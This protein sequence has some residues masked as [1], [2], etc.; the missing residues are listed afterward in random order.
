MGC[1]TRAG[2]RR[3]ALTLLD[4][5]ADAF[6]AVARLL[7]AIWLLRL[8]ETCKTLHEI[9]TQRV[10]RALVIASKPWLAHDTAGTCD[11]KQRYAIL[12]RAG[13]PVDP[14]DEPKLELSLE[15]L[16]HEFS[17]YFDRHPRFEGDSVV[18]MAGKIRTGMSDAEGY[19]G[20][21]QNVPDA[22]FL[23][24]PGNEF[25]GNVHLDR[26]LFFSVHVRRASDG[27]VAH[28]ASFDLESN[29]EGYIPN[30]LGQ[31]DPGERY[32]TVYRSGKAGCGSTLPALSRREPRKAPKWLGLVTAAGELVDA[33][34]SYP[35][36]NVTAWPMLVEDATAE[37]DEPG[38][39]D[40]AR[41]VSIELRK[42]TSN[43]PNFDHTWFMGAAS[44]TFPI[45]LTEVA[46]VL[47][48]LEWA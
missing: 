39:W 43:V 7:P 33:C 31:D 23:D 13:R 46:A 35:L 37:E 6:E 19:E 17:F 4:L 38:G 36:L 40:E 15:A 30:E 32:V 34:E 12:A 8:L 26:L 1:V 41:G 10:W 29:D 44:F 14:V 48:V 27:K 24:F 20:A 2:T 5:P 3:H 42:S 9:D 11:W 25:Q 22:V 28:L 21:Y 18:S 47:Q 16:Q 45:Q